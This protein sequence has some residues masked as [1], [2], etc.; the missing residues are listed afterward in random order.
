MTPVCVTSLDLYEYSSSVLVYVQEL[1]AQGFEK[2][3]WR[4]Q[5]WISYLFD[6]YAT[7]LHLGLRDHFG[8]HRNGLPRYAELLA[9]RSHRL[10]LTCRIGIRIQTWS[11]ICYFR[12]VISQSAAEP[13]SKYQR[14]TQS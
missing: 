6:S 1:R 9:L 10:S 11:E 12:R 2:L 8:G 3:M 14:D 4:P 13:V 7:E 5:P